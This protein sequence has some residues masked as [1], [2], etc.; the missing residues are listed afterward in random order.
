MTP[1]GKSSDKAGRVHISHRSSAGTME[2]DPTTQRQSRCDLHRVWRE[3]QLTCRGEYSLERLCALKEYQETQTYV[4]ALLV[5]VAT[6]LP[7]L[8]MILMLD[9][10]PLAEPSD[11]WKKNHG[12]WVRVSCGSFILALGATFQLRAM[13]PAAMLTLKKS[14]YLSAF[15]AA[16]YT[17]VMILVAKCWVFPTPFGPLVGSLPWNVFF[18]VGVVLTIGPDKLKQNQELKVQIQ[19]FSSKVN[20]E[21][22]FLL[23]FPAYNAI[24]LSL[25]GPY[26][27]AFVFVLPPFKFVLKRML[28]RVTSDLEDMVPVLIISIDVFSSLYQS[29]CMQSSGS[30]WTT[31][32]IIAIDGIQNCLSIR[33]LF[34]LVKEVEVLEEH[35]KASKGLMDC[36][37]QLVG[38][39]QQLSSVSLLQFRIRSCSNIRLPQEQAAF[40]KKMD[41]I[42]HELQLG[43]NLKSASSRRKASDSAAPPSHFKLN[44]VVPFPLHVAVSRNATGL[45]GPSEHL[46][47]SNQRPDA[48]QPE[49]MIVKKS[50]ELL[51]RCELILL[52]EYIESAIPVMYSIYLSILFYLPSAKYYPGMAEMTPDKLQ[53]AIT[54]ILIYAALE[55]FSLLCVHAVLKW[56]FNLSAVHQ[57]AFVCQNEWL[58]MQGLLLGWVVIVLQFTLAHFG[59]YSLLLSCMLA[60]KW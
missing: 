36:T 16:G 27:F 28:A 25:T 49:A 5:C 56:R 8:L 14:V 4:K 2:G 12:A 48:S 47:S 40:I 50:L 38:K 45:A 30:M 51:W 3:L 55:L 34:Q 17:V 21:S 52:V 53:H 20:V 37:L 10:V 7:P 1:N 29:K 54:S 60:S 18:F 19:R 15:T 39:P 42:Q 43:L 31:V 9:L 32:A 6:I 46:R 58:A 11:G 57:L 35:K 44:S 59:T 41:L 24:F 26:Q 23:L 33:R 13:V 22:T